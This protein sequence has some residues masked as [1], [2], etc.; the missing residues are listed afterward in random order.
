MMYE[1]ELAKRHIFANREFWE[2]QVTQ[3]NAQFYLI[4]LPVLISLYGISRTDTAYSCHSNQRLRGWSCWYEWFINLLK[5]Y[6]LFLRIPLASMKRYVV[7]EV[8]LEGSDQSAP[9]RSLISFFH[10]C[11]YRNG[12]SETREMETRIRLYKYANWFEHLQYAHKLRLLFTRDKSYVLFP[13][14]SGRSNTY[15]KT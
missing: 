11:M 3:R 13:H 8:K 14:L 1:H 9:P 5:S 2:F 4:L 6:F 12:K 10:L 15:L 7:A